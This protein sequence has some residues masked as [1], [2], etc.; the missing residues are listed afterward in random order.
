MQ[1][2][3]EFLMSQYQGSSLGTAGAA[4]ERAPL[5]ELDA[6]LDSHL[7]AHS[8]KL[9]ARRGIEYFLT[10]ARDF[11]VEHPPQTH[12]MLAQG[13]GVTLAGGFEVSLTPTCGDPEPGS[14]EEMTAHHVTEGRSIRGQAGVQDGHGIGVTGTQPHPALRDPA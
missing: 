10:F 12:I 2:I 3:L 6:E 14:M 7:H 1:D 5:D 4:P 11:L 8:D 9:A 13:F